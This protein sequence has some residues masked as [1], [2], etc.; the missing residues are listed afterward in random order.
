MVQSAASQIARSDVTKDALLRIA[1]PLLEGDGCQKLLLS[2]LSSEDNKPNLYGVRKLFDPLNSQYANME[3]VDMVNH[4]GIVL[5]SL[6]RPYVH[7]WNILHRGIGMMVSKDEDIFKTLQSGKIPEVYVHQRTSTKRVFPSLYDMFVGGVSSTGEEA[8]LT[9][10]REVAEELGLKHALEVLESSNKEDEQTLNPLS[11]KLFQCTVCT[12][13]NRC[14]VSMFTYTCDT[15]LE[16]ISWQ[17]E[18]VAWG[19]YVPYDIVELSGD[20]SIDRLVQSGDWPGSKSSGFDSGSRDHL[21]TAKEL[22]G[23]Y[24]NE[25]AWESWDYVPDGLLVWEAWKSYLNQMKE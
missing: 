12:S 24:G 25:H 14:V 22:K 13:Y 20:M 21:E 6:P 1:V 11:E 23:K 18:E 4:D 9:A 5:G 17:E 16:S 7:T 2:D 3:I 10:A 15:K 19:D 8:Q